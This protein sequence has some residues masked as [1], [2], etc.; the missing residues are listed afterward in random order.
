MVVAIIFA[1]GFGGGW[2]TKSLV[3]QDE[4]LD[5][6]EQVEAAPEP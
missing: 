5:R 1:L 4:R 2:L 3:D 6:L